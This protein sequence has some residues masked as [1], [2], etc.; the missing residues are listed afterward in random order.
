MYTS[1]IVIFSLFKVARKQFYL[2]FLE[3]VSVI[4]YFDRLQL[5]YNISEFVHYF[6]E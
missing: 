4:V 1:T 3:N 2:N 5:C 6:I